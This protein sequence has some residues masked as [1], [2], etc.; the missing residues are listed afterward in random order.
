MGK[1]RVPS[2]TRADPDPGRHSTLDWWFAPVA[3]IVTGLAGGG[4]AILVAT[5]GWGVTWAVLVAVLLLAS[6]GLFLAHKAEG[7]TA[8]VAPLCGLVLACL[9]AAIVGVIRVGGT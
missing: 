9:A 8:V 2:P 6:P 5:V 7:G 4:L 3:A 1:W